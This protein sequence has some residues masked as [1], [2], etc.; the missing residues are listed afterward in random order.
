MRG[1]R[2]VPLIFLFGFGAISLEALC[3]EAELIFFHLPLYL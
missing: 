3:E 1:L 2:K